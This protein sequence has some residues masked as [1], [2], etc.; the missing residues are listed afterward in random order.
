MT[1]RTETREAKPL[2]FEPIPQQVKQLKHWQEY[3]G[4]V[5]M[6]SIPSV[7]WLRLGEEAMLEQ[8]IAPS[9]GSF[10][11]A[12][13][14]E[15]EEISIEIPPL[16]GFDIHSP[17]L[18]SNIRN[19]LRNFWAVVISKALQTS[20]PVLKTAIAVFSDPAED[21]QQVVL[22]VFTEASASQA[23]AFWE[24]LENDIQDWMTGLDEQ[25]RPIFLR[26]ISLRIHWQ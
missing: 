13:R 10:S 9:Y 11:T 14:V 5:L 8:S 16:E 24:G 2:L 18:T 6:S 7:Q 26:D 22:R 20:F 1:L 19:L 17:V 25:N 4:E 12:T 23:I 15:E 3:G 21:R